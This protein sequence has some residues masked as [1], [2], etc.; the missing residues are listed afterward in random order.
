MQKRLMDMQEDSIQRQDPKALIDGIP[1]NAIDGEDAFE[2][3]LDKTANAFRR[4][5]IFGYQL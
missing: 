4:R 3:D 1:A 5:S 2:D